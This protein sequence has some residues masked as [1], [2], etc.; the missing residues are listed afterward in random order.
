MTLVHCKTD[1]CVEDAAKVVQPKFPCSCM[2]PHWLVIFFRCSSPSS[3]YIYVE[4]SVT[5]AF[6]PTPASFDLDEHATDVRSCVTAAW[7]A[8]KTPG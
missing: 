1:G 7:C 4:I 8:L 2:P 3:Q 5:V 6:N